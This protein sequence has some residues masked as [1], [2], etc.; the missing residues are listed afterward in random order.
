M[1]W[2]VL[3][4]LISI[5]IAL[6]VVWFRPWMR[7]T[8]WGVRFLNWV[9]PIERVLWWK[10]ETILWARLQMVTGLL[11]TLLTQAG[12]IDI[13]PLMPF[14]PDAYEPLVKVIWNALPLT[15]TIMGWINERLRKDTTKPLEI[16]AMRTDAP[17]EVKVAA[18][19][20][21]LKSAEAVEAVKDAKAV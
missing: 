1:T 16:V 4:T 14:V 20:A 7:T 10:S 9:E 5:L 3:L 19:E 6:Y 12:S 11:L 21:E 18:A 8:G 13:T 17:V 2:L 15:I